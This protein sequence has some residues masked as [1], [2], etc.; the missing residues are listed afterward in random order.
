MNEQV[1]MATFTA[2]ES[3]HFFSAFL[4]SVFTIGTFVQDEAGIKLIRQGELEAS[5]TAFALA[6][7]VS[8]LTK[9]NLP[10]YFTLITIAVM[11][12]IYES[13]LQ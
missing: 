12:M 4:P 1:L 7:V 10:L 13:A 8:Q 11:I 6:F 3:A 2:L 5:A 9:S